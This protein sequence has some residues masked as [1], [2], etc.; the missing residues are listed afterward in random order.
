MADARFEKLCASSGISVALRQCR[1]LEEYQVD[2][3]DVT[4]L[5]LV[6]VP[7]TSRGAAHASLKSLRLS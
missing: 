2:L 5:E 1:E 3:S 6:I 4:V 7:D